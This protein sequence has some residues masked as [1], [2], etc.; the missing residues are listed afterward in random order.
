M[1]LNFYCQEEENNREE[2]INKYK[3]LFLSY[4]NNNPSL[5]DALIQMFKSTD[6]E[7]KKVHELTEDILNQCKERI[8]PDFNMIQNKYGNITKEDA[9]II[10]TYTCESIEK[11]Y[12]PYRILNQNLVS[13][14]RSKGV[15]NISKYLY[16]FLKSLRKLPK[17]YP[18]NKHLY[19]CINC[20]VN[21]CKDPNNEK[22][23]PFITGNK[24]TFWTFTSTSSEPKMTYSFLGKE[25][26]MKK[27]TIFSL[28]GDIW[29]YDIELFNYFH[30]KEILLEPER[31]FIVGNVLPPV[32]NL[33]NITCIILKTPLVINNNEKED[34]NE[35]INDNNNDLLINKY[36]VKLEMEARINN[37]D[38]YTSGIGILC[39]IPTKYI[40][41][42][43]TFNTIINLDFINNSK[44]LILSN[45]N[46]EIEIDM[47]IDRYKYTNKELNYTIIEILE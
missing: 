29:G 14:D 8:D 31:K 7:N 25:E 36:V 39:N 13:K 26:Q 43:I 35:I 27:G 28:T 10:C 2:S 46:K 32:N 9:Y 20:H 18:K 5:K 4:E 23:I 42:L 19:R 11:M 47:K 45:N 21:L 37:K 41:V 12:S 40:K 3:N 22:L 15:R 17:Y 38:E 16:I 30:E 34:Y 24:K 44:K 33:I 6:L 1:S